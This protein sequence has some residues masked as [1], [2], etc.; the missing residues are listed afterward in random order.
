V[1]SRFHQVEGVLF[2]EESDLSFK[3]GL[4]QSTGN[5]YCVVTRVFPDPLVEVLSE[6]DDFGIH[7]CSQ[8]GDVP[9]K[10]G[11]VILLGW[12]CPYNLHQKSPK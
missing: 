3:G 10:A 6:P 8:Y 11:V 5:L 7:T 9:R 12:F 1:E 2:S 4:K